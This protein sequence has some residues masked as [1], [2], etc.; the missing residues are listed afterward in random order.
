[1][2]TMICTVFKC[3][4][5]TRLQLLFLYTLKRKTKDNTSDTLPNSFSLPSTIFDYKESTFQDIQEVKEKEI[6][7]GHSEFT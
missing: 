6:F 7:L 2:L 4:G 5:T 3:S 1:M